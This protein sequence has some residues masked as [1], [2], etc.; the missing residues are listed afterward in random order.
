MRY[1]IKNILNME[2]NMG[3]TESIVEILKQELAEGK[4]PIN[5][6]FPSEYE[7]S[8]RFNVNK[9]TANKA[10]TLL[11]TEGLLERGRGGKGTI[12]CSTIKFPRHHVVYLG[13]LKHSYF[14]KLGH[15]IQTAALENNSLMSVVTP[16]IEQFH[17]VLQSLNNSSID[18][19]LT[20]SFGLLPEMKKPVVYLEDQNGEIKY[21][22]Y[23]ACDSYAA[24]Y[25]LMR[26]IIAR[27]H[28][29]IAILFHYMNNPKRLDGFYDAMKE[30]GITDYK[31]RTFVSMD[32]TQGESN[33]ILKQIQKKFPGFTA[34]SACS[35]DDIFRM[36]KSMQRSGIPWEGKIAMTGIGN[37]PEIVSCCSIATVEQHPFRI[38]GIAFR[39]LLKKIKNPEMTI[40]ELVDIELINMKNIPVIK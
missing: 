4:Y 35:D 5:S 28:R 31:E 19:I 1:I 33:M 18:G 16:T 20:S 38:G 12:V 23:V 21:P 32:F 13:S 10:V 17:S 29:N 25:Q 15:G 7:L 9:K 14:A 2:L 37:I 39:K 34:I 36:I 22:D 40:N 6:R 26:E 30:A 8:D 11:V 24:G 3:K 27:G